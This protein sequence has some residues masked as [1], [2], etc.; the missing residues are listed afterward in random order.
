MSEKLIIIGGSITGVYAATQLV[1]GKYQG[2]ITI[3]DQKDV[4][5][6]NTYPLSKE[7]MMDLEEREAPYLKK[8]DYYKEN[9]INLKLGTKVEAVDSEKR[10]VKTDKGETLAYDKLLIATGSKLR[11]VDIPGDDAEGVFYLRE[12]KDALTI[13]DWVK[14]IEDVVIIGSGFIGMEFASTFTQMGKKVSLLIRS[15]KPLEKIL[16]PEVSSYFV[17]MHEKAGVNFIYNEESQEFLKDEQGRIKSIITKTGKE[18]KADMVII[19]VG[20][21]PNL[22]FEIE[23][24]DTD[25]DAII[26]NE[27]GETSLADIYAAGDIVLWPYEN[28][29]IHI[30][31]WENAWGQGTSVAKNIMEEKSSAFKTIP[32]FWT[33]QYDHSFEYLGNTRTWDKTVL[34]GSMKEKKFSLAYLDE[35]NYPL[36]ILFV[37]E[38]EERKDIEALLARKEPLDPEKFADSSQEL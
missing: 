28:R 33:D 29:L 9:N 11:K 25:R 18:I 34:R 36:A 13:K 8:E 4:L 20:V 1:R 19:A 27:Y 16:G 35:S 14:N 2:E 3:I 24:L 22:S 15:G 10:L 17:K 21:Q 5:P 31:H 23:G 26:V 32:Y 38:A 7:W 6:Y 37:N 30:E 12:W